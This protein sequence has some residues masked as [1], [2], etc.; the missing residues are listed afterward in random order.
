MILFLNSIVKSQ[1]RLEQSLSI[2]LIRIRTYIVKIMRH[3]SRVLVERGA[4]VIHNNSNQLEAP[5]V[6]AAK[7]SRSCPVVPWLDLLM[8]T[9]YGGEVDSYEGA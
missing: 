6:S 9:Y 8:T 3:F 4:A 1:G 7:C 5:Q 2:L